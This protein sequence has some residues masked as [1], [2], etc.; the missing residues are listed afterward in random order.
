MLK[1]MY[2]LFALIIFA[3]QSVFSSSVCA[4]QNTNMPDANYAWHYRLSYAY[5]LA[6]DFDLSA[7]EIQEALVCKPHAKR[8]TD[9]IVLFL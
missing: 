7:L 9:F 3:Q 1:I 4:E 2:A 6:T 8:L 5:L